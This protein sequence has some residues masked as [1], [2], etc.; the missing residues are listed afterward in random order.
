MYETDCDNVRSG[1]FQGKLVVSMRW[2]RKGLTERVTELM[3]RHYLSH[4][5][6][7]PID[8]ETIDLS[9]P[10]WGE[11]NHPPE[12]DYVNYEPMFWACGVTGQSA[13]QHAGDKIDEFVVTHA[14]GNMFISDVVVENVF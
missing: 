6:P 9:R 10:K 14:P 3:Q 12:A 4:G 5:P 11:V 2:I 1:P 8:R 7:I 13:L